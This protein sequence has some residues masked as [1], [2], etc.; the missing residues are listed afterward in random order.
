MLQVCIILD[1]SV[2]CHNRVL[3][4]LDVNGHTVKYNERL[5]AFIRAVFPSCINVERVT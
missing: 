3:I 4:S 1:L 5:A 2:P